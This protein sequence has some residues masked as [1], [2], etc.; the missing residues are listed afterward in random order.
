MTLLLTRFIHASQH[1]PDNSL[2]SYQIG[3]LLED[4]EVTSIIVASGQAPD[5]VKTKLQDIL[6]L[7]KG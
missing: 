6:Q 4:E 1:T 2:F 3:D 7:L 5:E